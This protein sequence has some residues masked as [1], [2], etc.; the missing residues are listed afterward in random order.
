MSDARW[1]EVDADIA[2]AI[3]HF[4]KSVELYDKGGFDDPGI[5]GYQAEMALM[6]ALQSAHTSLEAG[7]VR[8][9]EILGEEK[10][11]GEGWHSDL[12]RRVGATLPGRRPPILGAAIAKA[13][14]ET[15][16]FRH[17]A[18]H[19][20][21]SFEVQE[22]SATIDAAKALTLGLAAEIAAFKA[23]IDPAQ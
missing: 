6:H 14:N 21:D 3:R 10:P 9:L 8:I 4:K 12:I 5:N 15:R 19:N 13:A 11:V 20:Y 2:A 22:T 16:K 17:R 7:L 1:F 18:T 23:A